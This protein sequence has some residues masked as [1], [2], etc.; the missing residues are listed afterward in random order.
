MAVVD[1]LPPAVE[2]VALDYAKTFLRVDTDDDDVLI[3]DFIKSARIRVESI[4]GGSLIT[5]TRRYTSAKTE[6]RSVFLNH[7]S[8]DSI[9]AVRLVSNAEVIDIPLSSLTVNLRCQ[10]PAISLTERQ[11]WSDYLPDFT[12]F[13]IDFTAGY[14]PAAENVPMPLR[15]A[16]LLLL[17]QSYEFRDSERPAPLPMMVEALLMPHRTLRL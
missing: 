4:T 11:S 14:G 2:P 3:A 15:Q 12:S 5:R 13:E 8:V 16:I 1:I 10:P 17:A 9:Q 6:G 7:Q